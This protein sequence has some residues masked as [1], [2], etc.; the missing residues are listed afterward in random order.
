MMMAVPSSEDAWIPIKRAQKRNAKTIAGRHLTS[1]HIEIDTDVEFVLDLIYFFARSLTIAP[2]PPEALGSQNDVVEAIQFVGK[3]QRARHNAE[4]LL[5]RASDGTRSELFARR[6][7]VGAGHGDRAEIGRRVAR[8]HVDQG[9]FAR[10]V[11]AEQNEDLAFANV[12]VDGL[13]GK[14]VADTPRQTGGRQNAGR[15]L[16]RRF[17]DLGGRTN[18]YRP[19]N[20]LN[21]HDAP[22]AR[23]WW[24]SMAFRGLAAPGSN[25]DLPAI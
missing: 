10:A 24:R 25:T 5:E 22:L 1:Q 3:C 14:T 11:V 12:K 15:S 17:R 19:L 6:L 23:N 9:A 8:Q 4:A 7:V 20:G 18:F 16:F 21:I 2:W 13:V